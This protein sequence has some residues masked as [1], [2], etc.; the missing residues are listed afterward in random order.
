[1]GDLIVEADGKVIAR[2][3]DLKNQLGLIRAGASVPIE[4]FRGKELNKTSI[5]I[6]HYKDVLKMSGIKMISLRILQ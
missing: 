5:K 3:A 4:Y 6:A 1:M 2:A